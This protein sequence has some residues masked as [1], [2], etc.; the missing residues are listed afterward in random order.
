VLPVLKK[1]WDDWKL[2]DIVLY[3]ESGACMNS[4]GNSNPID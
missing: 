3:T 2:N 1:T 4:E